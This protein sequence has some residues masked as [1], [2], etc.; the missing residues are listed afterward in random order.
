MLTSTYITKKLA[1]RAAISSLI[2]VTITSLAL[3]I[4]GVKYACGA[5][6]T[7]LAI[8]LGSWLS[9]QVAL[10]GRVQGA[11]AV[12]ARL[13]LAFLLKLVSVIT[14]LLLG[15]CLWRLPALGLLSGIIIGLFFQVLTMTRQQS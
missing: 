12:I 8:A 11:V 7:G 15:F 10:G 1:L 14:A 9:A 13:I 4:F 5:T 6:L 2:A 3:L